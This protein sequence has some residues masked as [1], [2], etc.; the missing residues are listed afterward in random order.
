ML[1]GSTGSPA[2]TVTLYWLPLGAGGR[3]VRRNGRM[4]EAL[5]ARHQHRA[6]CDLYHSALE[7]RIGDDR[8]V[9]EMTP[10]WGNGTADRGVVLEGPVGS[11]WLGR[12]AL[13]RYEVRRWRD[14][15]IPDIGEAVTDPLRVSEDLTHAED[16]LQLVPL[17]PAL[18]WG[19]DELQAGD[20]W[21]SNSLTAWLL[22]SSGHAMG[23]IEPPA[24]GRAPGWHAGLAAA[25]RPSE[26]AFSLATPDG[27]SVRLT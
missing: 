9:I 21:N 27:R 23:S 5:V 13:F 2:A 1:R 25:V 15:V 3:F 12:S 16:L 14:G 24:H 4:F 17:V 11:R 6:A 8:F 10:V 7:V 19:R 26:R 20:M 22:A 18:T